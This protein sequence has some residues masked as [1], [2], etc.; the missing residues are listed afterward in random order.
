[1]K[2]EFPEL[3]KEQRYEIAE[4]IA[5]TCETLNVGSIE[6]FQKKFGFSAETADE[7]GWNVEPLCAEFELFR[8][9]DCMWWG[10]IGEGGECNECGGD[11]V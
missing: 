3:T 9:E 10:D 5:G 1:M 2:T 6:Y 7:L 4:S 8:C 11:L